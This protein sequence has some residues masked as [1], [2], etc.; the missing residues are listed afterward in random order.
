MLVVYIYVV[1]CCIYYVSAIQLVNKVVCVT[2]SRMRDQ[3]VS[4]VTV[5]RE[6]DGRCRGDGDVDF[7]Q[8]RRDRAESRETRIIIVVIVDVIVDVTVSSRHRHIG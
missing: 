8:P 5:V 1:L 7:R 3:L 4:L 6:T 2:M